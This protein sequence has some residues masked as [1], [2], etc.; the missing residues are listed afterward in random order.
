MKNQILLTLSLVCFVGVTNI[1]AQENNDSLAIKGGG[2]SVKGWTGKIDA[3][4]LAAG[5]TLNSAKLVK[6]AIPCT[7]PPVLL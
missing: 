1:A 4:E 6:G 2:V 7:S 5:M 3:K